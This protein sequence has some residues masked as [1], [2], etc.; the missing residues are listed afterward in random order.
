MKVYRKEKE[1]LSRGFVWIVT[2][3]IGKWVVGD[4]ATKM[5]E[6]DQSPFAFNK[7]LLEFQALDTKIAKR[8]MKTL[9]AE[10]K[11]NIEYPEDLQYSNQRPTVTGRQKVYQILLFFRSNKTHDHTMSLNDV[12]ILISWKMSF[13]QSFSGSSHPRSISDW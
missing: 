3:E 6:L 9:S 8:I 5:V 13:R 4:L 10:N 1:V 11:Q 2:P 7:H 12:N